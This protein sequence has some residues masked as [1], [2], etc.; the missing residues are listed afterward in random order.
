MAT[1]EFSKQVDRPTFEMRLPA[2]LFHC[3]ALLVPVMLALGAASPLSASGVTLITHGFNSN[4]TDWIIPMAGEVINYPNF[5]GSN[6]SCYQISIT[7]N[8]SGQ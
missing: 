8:A 6:Y 4:V 1:L 5:P 2:Q 7:R 3:F